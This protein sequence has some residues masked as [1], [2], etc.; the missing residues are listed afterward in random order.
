MPIKLLRRYSNR[1][2][3]SKSRS[4]FEQLENRVYLHAETIKINFQTDNNINVGNYPEL[5]DYVADSGQAFGNRGNG[6]TYGWLD[7]NLRP[8]NQTQTR[9]RGNGSSPDERYDTLNHFIKGDNHS[10][11][12]ELEN[13]TYQLRIVAGDPSH[14]DQ[15]NDFTITSGNNQHAIDDPDGEDNWDEFSVDDF[16]V[17]NG[18]LRITPETSGD[19]Q[20]IAFLE[21]THSHDE[22]LSAP[23]LANLPA[24]NV[25]ALTARLNGIVTDAG[26]DPPNITIYYGDNDAGTSL[27]GWDEGISIGPQDGSFST[28][29]SGLQP[30]TVYYY[31]SIGFNLGGFAWAPTTTMFTTQ[32]I[33]SATVE[34]VAASNVSAFEATVGGAVTSTGF[35]TPNI[36]VFWGDNDGSDD[37]VNWDNAVDLG[38][39]STDF[40]HVLTGLTP[41]TNYFFRSRATNSVGEAWTETRTFSTLT[42][43]PATVGSLAALDIEAFQVLIS[44]QIADDG[45]DTPQV[46]LFFG[47]NDGGTNVA[48]W[49]QQIDL[50]K[51]DNFFSSTIHSLNDNTTYFFRV[52]T[53]NAGGT[54][55][56]SST[57]S[58]STPLV[59]LA[60]IVNDPAIQITSSSA[61]LR[62]TVTDYGNDAPRVHFYYGKTDGGTDKAAW[63]SS[64]E[65]GI[66][67][68]S[69]A[70]KIAGLSPNTQYYF[71]SFANNAAGESWADTS[72]SFTTADSPPLLITEFMARNTNTLTTRIRSSIDESFDNAFATDWIE[73]HN[74]GDEPADLSGMFLTDDANNRTKWQ[75]PVGTTLGAG[76]YMIVAASAENILNPALDRN[77]YLHTNFKLSGEGEFLAI[78]ESDGTIVHSYG[79]QFPQQREDISY[80]IDSSGDPHYYSGVTAGSANQ[81]GTINLVADTT[82][83]IDRGFYATPF[84][85]TI[86]S[87]TPGATLVY[88]LDGSK[89][90]QSNGTRVQPPNDV[91]PPEA[92]MRVSTTS[93]VRAFAFKSGFEPTNIDTHSYIF[94]EDVLKQA[95]NPSNGR[96]AVPEGFPSSWR[97]ATG[98]YQVDP[99]IVNHFNQSN[100]LVADDLLSVETISIVMDVEDLFGSNQIYLS[101]SGQPRSASFELISQD[102]SEEFQ[103]DGS[104]QVQGGS[105]TNRW[106]DYKLSLR[107]KF[108]EPFGPT[109]LNHALYEDSPVSRYDNIILDGVLNHSWLHSSQH[110]QPQY[111]QDQYV[112]DLHNA[113]GG[114][115]PYGRYMHVYL[116]GLYWGMYYVHDR[117]DHAWAAEMLGGEK[118]SYHAVKH[119]GSNVINNGNGNSA[120]TSYNAMVTAA[121]AVRNDP[122]NMQKWETLK[123]Q[124]DVDNFITYSL[125]NW[126]TGNHD[127]PHKNW[128]A[129][130]PDGGQWR[131]HSWDAEHV[132]DSNNDVGESPND[133]HNRLKANPEYKIL[134]ADHIHKN[135]F[136]DGVLTVENSSAL[137]KKRM[138]EI[139]RAIVGE[140]ARWGDN[141]SSRAHTRSDWINYNGEGR[142]L[143]GR[144]FTSRSRTV[145]NQLKSAN[146]YPNLD[147]PEF[148]QHGG[149][150]AANFQIAINNPDGNGTIYYTVDGSDPRLP[151]GQLNPDAIAY[152]QRF[153]LPNSAKVKA[154]IRNGSTWSA[155]TEADFFVNSPS[156]GDLVVTEINYHPHSALT[157]F[158]EPA[159][160]PDRFEFIEIQNRSDQAV[161]LGGVQFKQVVTNGSHQG[162]DFEF[163]SQTLSPG[164]HL[165]V[166]KDLAAFQARYGT[167][168]RIA[169]G[170]DGTEYS[171]NLNNNGEQISLFAGDGTLLQQFRYNDSGNWPQRADGRAS[172]LEAVSVDGDFSRPSN[173][174]N[175][176]GFGG[177]PGLA[178]E[179]PADDVVI[180]EL[181]THTDLPQIDS[182]ELHNVSQN[183]IDVGN[184]YISD[185]RANYLRYQI[186][187]PR[188]VS[189]G[190]Y[191]SFNENQLGFGFRG[192]QRDDAWLI[193]A[194]Q[195][196]KPTRFMDHVEFGATDNG[197]SLGRWPDGSGQLFPMTRV[198]TNGPN[199]RP[200]VGD[201]VISEVNYHPS[202]PAQGSPLIDDQLEFIEVWNHTSRPSDISNWRLNRAIDYT[203][204]PN[205]ILGPD[206]G[207]VVVPFEPTNSQMAGEF[208]LNYGISS[209]VVLMGPFSGG[210]D[211]GGETVEL[212]RP[213][214][215]NQLG[216]GYVLVD[217][218]SFDDQAPWPTAAD[219]G[220]DSLQR[221]NPDLFGNFAPSW[222]AASPSPGAVEFAQVENPDADFNSDGQVDALD[223]D[224]LCRAISNNDLAFD[225]NSDQV[226]DREDQRFLIED[227]LN[228]SFGDANL[229]GI[230]DSSDLI[231][232]FTHGQYENDQPADSGWATGD[233]NC[234]QE[235]DSGDLIAAFTNGSYVPGS[236]PKWR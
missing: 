77:G 188:V 145:L 78:V 24:S 124:L 81:D 58:F 41:N 102:G 86:R 177:S 166:V 201:V 82:F 91:T 151:G 6:L 39:S 191:L 225:L 182:I 112:A 85:L 193:A 37:P 115:S 123:S 164:E 132:T 100:R 35:D 220:G 141:R 33:A 148:N 167:N 212:D 113:M 62:G 88:T 133:L 137:W 190:G 165:V 7:G 23:A 45:N 90:T 47:D 197:V 131:F 17:T 203:F 142:G 70:E 104:V 200:V 16:V 138:D 120:R 229:D 207:I 105:S 221:T 56:S 79:P 122:Q 224:L 28:N 18:L 185:S 46:T 233:W 43:S 129:T 214:D 61:E 59:V 10:W 206:S 38:Q 57:G 12:I 2:N 96:Q 48:N 11:Q 110:T 130:A 199:E 92:T 60:Q 51:I 211:N 111:I 9:N 163:A 222:K 219:A 72:A 34:S 74:P 234:D 227:I 218:V 42:V 71:R 116:N 186:P 187:G 174:R 232:I 109:K 158:D 215:P 209:D 76:D 1:T 136:N 54:S 29:I 14:T 32:S 80:G 55:W 184:W 65:V 189:P 139:D 30:N 235:F 178:N 154:R 156:P 146:L 149:N 27:I 210:L 194:D 4:Q 50:G 114:M 162:I 52:R 213:E 169:N 66:E 89:P 121:N 31:R 128:Y 83:S 95:T 135:F 93:L 13:G 25:G 202:D 170:V 3:Q 204:E 140:S 228:T 176:T 127:W 49:D 134:M 160:D 99:D 5:T 205:T 223:V 21:I 8:D 226:V 217:R 26:G 44:G 231:Q 198:T 103:I 98:D 159:V 36:T 172:S 183:A 216:L 230:F 20:K 125:A 144:Y 117:P 208:R 175:S 153:R 106:K 173:W 97:G 53:D 126:F 40:S 119:S 94:P 157:Q 63:E 181:L 150:I 161:D 75:F 147:A 192:E 87:A 19:N 15:V 22:E 179:R 118:E 67:F 168:A 196:G 84:D 107:L 64:V 152:S 171:G 236:R 73:I 143:L 68:G 108:Q 180:N 195:N 155:V 69:Y 101:G